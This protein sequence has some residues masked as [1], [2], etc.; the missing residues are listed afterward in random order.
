MFAVT[1][2]SDD[3]STSLATT[4]RIVGGSKVADDEQ[5]QKSLPFYAISHPFNCGATLIHPDVLLTAGHC[6]GVFAPGRTISLGAGQFRNGASA[7][8]TRT[9]VREL[10]HPDYNDKT[11]AYDVLLVQLDRPST[12]PV[13]RWNTHPEWP[14]AN[15]K[16]T[17]IG[18]GDTEFEGR[19]SSQLLQVELPIV[20][21]DYC[22]SK[23]V[24]D[25]EVLSD[26]ML[27]AGGERGRDACQGRTTSTLP[28]A[29]I[30]MRGLFV[31]T[32]DSGSPLIDFDTGLILGVVSWGY[33]CGLQGFPGVY[34]KT[35][36]VDGFLRQGICTLSSAPPPYCSN[37]RFVEKSDTTTGLVAIPDQASNSFCET[38]Q[39]I[40]LGRP[41]WGNTVQSLQT[42]VFA[43]GKW[44]SERGV[45]YTFRGTN[46][47]IQ[48]STCDS[49]DF[50]TVV[51][52]YKGS[53]ARL[54][55][56][57]ENDDSCGYGSLTRF[58]S[59]LDET[60]FVFVHGHGDGVGRFR[61]AMDSMPA[62]P[63]H[64][65]GCVDAMPLRPFETMLGTT[66]G[67]SID[68]VEACDNGFLST[69]PG[70]WYT[71]D[72]TNEKAIVDTCV[73]NYETK[74]SI[75]TG[76]CTQ[77][78][79]CVEAQSDGCGTGSVVSFFAEVGT[80]YFVHVHGHDRDIGD[81][82]V[83]IVAVSESPSMTPTISPA[84]TAQKPG[85]ISLKS[86]G[87]NIFCLVKEI[88]R[89]ILAFLWAYAAQA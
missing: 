32:G 41:L 73:S 53:C 65:D 59:E 88:F 56:V 75:Y 58:F 39:P 55:C 60:Y 20:D 85:I 17:V 34:A 37:G 50:D 15:G 77:Q 71:Y 3:A 21:V 51:N 44:V 6:A 9:S 89:I 10:Q 70:I 52:V 25:G 33:E 31:C 62:S 11:L 42:D 8:E 72:G 22:N 82:E 64:N 13:A 43:C 35:S 36:A 16:A 27:C 26:L 81:F 74:I 87:K 14:L 68:T 79:T 47:G 23:Y 24:Y 18:F 19:Y 83:T 48:L 49:F 57:S 28:G 69:A 63:P 78:L 45:W 67:A 5:Q 54:S 40:D 7:L 86:C 1:V 76:S 12:L 2:L 84:P 29:K 4:P 61:L 30:L 38:A 66:T 46:A 80:T